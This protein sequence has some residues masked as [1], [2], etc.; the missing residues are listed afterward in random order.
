MM[1]SVALRILRNAFRRDNQGEVNMQT[2]LRITVAVVAL[3]CG[4]GVGVG[5]CN[6][7]DTSGGAMDLSAGGADMTTP[8]S[9]DMAR[10]TGDAGLLPLA[11]PC[12]G[13]SDCASDLCAAYAGGTKMLCTYAC[14]KNMPAP[15]CTA[16]SDGTCNGM[17]YCKFPGM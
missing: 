11:S 9:H 14:T 3:A 5:G 16:P 4:V 13:N 1:R 7:D 10:A 12:G 6:S 15:M 17:G 2:I 8:G